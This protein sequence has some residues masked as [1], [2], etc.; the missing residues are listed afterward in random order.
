MQ[1]DEFGFKIVEKLPDP[2][3][4]EEV[5]QDFLKIDVTDI[6]DD[7]PVM[8]YEQWC[9]FIK[10]FYQDAKII[11]DKPTVKKLLKTIIKTGVPADL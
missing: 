7:I 2:A 1:E 5:E 8:D 4:A 6:E 10:A 11:R 9:A 3:E